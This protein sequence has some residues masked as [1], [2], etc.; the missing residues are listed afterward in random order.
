MY[1]EQQKPEGI[2]KRFIS[3]TSF[4]KNVLFFV[5]IYFS[6]ELK[7]MDNLKETYALF[8]SKKILTFS[9][10]TFLVKSYCNEDKRSCSKQESS[11]KNL[12]IQQFL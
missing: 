3:W 1:I 8:F 4:Y 7:L 9:I 11:T 2:F 6:R 5:F 12:M 10:A